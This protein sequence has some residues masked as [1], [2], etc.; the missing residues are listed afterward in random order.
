MT[1]IHKTCL[2]LQRRYSEVLAKLKSAEK[3]IEFYGD[4]KSWT[5]DHH[6]YADELYE[7]STVDDFM[8]TIRKD[9]SAVETAVLDRYTVG[10]VGGKKARQWLE[11]NQSS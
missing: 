9:C 3:V 8:D 1:D 2:D 11:E 5:I 7:I 10:G 6:N 4:I